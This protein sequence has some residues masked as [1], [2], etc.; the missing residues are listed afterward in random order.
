MSQETL[1][2]SAKVPTFYS[3]KEKKAKAE[4]SDSSDDES[5]DPKNIVK[6]AKNVAKVIGGDEKLTEMELLSKILGISIKDDPQ[7]KTNLK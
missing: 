1:A 7:K 3:K 4:S 5:K 2:S 6:A